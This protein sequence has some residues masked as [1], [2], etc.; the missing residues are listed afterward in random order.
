MKN[1]KLKNYQLKVLVDVLDYN[2]PFQDGRIRRRFFD[3][4]LPRMQQLEKDRVELC[5]TLCVKD[6]EKNPILEDGAYTFGKNQEKFQ[7][8]YQEMMSED[9]IFEVNDFNVKDVQK[10]KELLNR[11]NKELGTMDTNTCIEIWDAFESS[12]QEDTKPKKK[13]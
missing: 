1:I 6:K 11:S 7:K 4:L 2:M 12:I 10:I 3:A 13:K 5:T 9:F 8:Q